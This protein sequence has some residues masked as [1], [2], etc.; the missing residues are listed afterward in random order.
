[1]QQ[2]QQHEAVIH[3]VYQAPGTVVYQATPSPL[4]NVPLYP[5]FP[6]PPH[7][8]QH[9]QS[10]SPPPPSPPPPAPEAT[11]DNPLLVSDPNA[12]HVEFD[13]E[14]GYNYACCLVTTVSAIV[15]SGLALFCI[16]C[17]DKVVRKEVNS[18]QCVVTDNRVILKSGWLNRS[19]RFIPL[20]RV[21]DVNVQENIVQRH[22]GATAVEIQTAGVGI[23]RMPEAY[24]LAPRDAAAVRK[25]ILSRRDQ[26]MYR[27]GFY[28]AGQSE[29]GKAVEVDAKSA[30]QLSGYDAAVVR[31]LRDLKDSVS[32]IEAQISEGVRKLGA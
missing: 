26:L 15:T 25:A 6:Q 24:L 10:S 18:Q 28:R 31:E 27:R 7:P 29:D 1:M 23:G 2:S 16:P 12:F 19:T 22:F 9:Q 4:P 11:E 5:A 8:P 20:D 13:Y 21:Q 14:M 3:S 32:R 30:S 17:I